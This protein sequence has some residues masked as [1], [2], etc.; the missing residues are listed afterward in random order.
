MASTAS[1]QVKA[2]NLVRRVVQRVRLATPETIDALESEVFDVME[3][4]LE[5]MG[6]THEKVQLEV[7]KAMEMARKRV[8]VME[9]KRQEQADSAAKPLK[10]M[11]EI[12]GL[13]EALQTKHTCLLAAACLDDSAELQ[14][15]EVDGVKKLVEE[16]NADT[17]EFTARCV[18]LAAQIRPA[19]TRDEDKEKWRILGNEM[20]Q[21]KKN[22]VK[23]VS[24]A[25]AAIAQA[26]EATRKAKF[27]ERKEEVQE[28]MS[29]SESSFPLAVELVKE[30]EKLMPVFLRPGLRK[31][32]DME[33]YAFSVDAAI[34]D[35]KKAVEATRGDICQ[36][37]GLFEDEDDKQLRED[38]EAF[39]AKE[40]KRMLIRLG[41]LDRQIN[42][43][44]YM[45]GYWR[46][47]E[48]AARNKGLFVQGKME[49]SRKLNSGEELDVSAYDS[50]ESLL[51]LAE[52]EVTSTFKYKKMTRE[53]M[54][55]T[56]SKI[57]CL[58]GHAMADW[59]A[60]NQNVCPI[61][62]G[63]DEESKRKLREFAQS[64]L[65]KRVKN[66]MGRLQ[67]RLDRVRNLLKY[68]REDI[69]KIGESQRRAARNR[70]GR[71]IQ[72]HLSSVGVDAE[73]MFDVSATTGVMD[74]A[75][76]LVFFNGIEATC[77]GLLIELTIDDVCAL[78]ASLGLED[79]CRL[80]KDMFLRLA[81]P[82]KVV[83]RPTTLTSVMEIKCSS[84]VRTLKVGEKVIVLEGPVADSQTK[85]VRVRALKDASIGWVSI[86]SN[87]GVSFLKDTVA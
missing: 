6:E 20:L 56:A 18:K 41:Q 16:F 57:D 58:L 83:L 68:F 2:A 62:P 21:F 36:Q 53:E 70:I 66:R 73:K 31:D 63:L 32:Y 69:N 48:K 71:A 8:A 84:L 52:T 35:A 50:V 77:D 30:C 46:A 11:E 3:Q 12:T 1:D 4:Q 61:D 15:H 45:L 17:E 39:F 5:N 43:C 67:L 7:D 51:K 23:T 38:L 19:V 76:F 14:Y 75:D 55:E 60:A 42:R 85:R 22:I 82:C 40:S 72:D 81:C 86:S 87:A 24:N 33:E 65:H 29:F 80:T 26:T 64:K 47:D 10:L 34:D 49:L 9:E 74:E 78:F 79:N 44:G 28:F 54:E 37:R 13:M 59:G 25:R 27:E